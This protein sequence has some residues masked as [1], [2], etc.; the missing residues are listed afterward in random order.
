MR[1]LIFSYD[2][3]PSVG[4]IQSAMNSLAEGIASRSQAE[5][6]RL[7]GLVTQTHADR[8]YDQRFGFTVF[9]RPGLLRLA[10]LIRDCDVLHLAGPALRPLVLAK[11]LQRKVVIQH[12]GYQAICPDGLLL[13]SQTQASCRDSFSHGDWINCLRC[14]ANNVGWI[15]GLLSVGLGY[16]RR[17]LVKRASANV[18]VSDHVKM[19]LGLP[20]SSTIY[21]GTSA[22][23]TPLLS[24]AH[25][26]FSPCFV[27][28]GRLVPEKGV[29]VLLR[30]SA[31]L[32]AGRKFRLRI[33]GDGPELLRLKI[34]ASE[35]RLDQIARFCGFVQGQ[36]LAD[37]IDDSVAVVMP[38][39]CEE[40]APLSAI[41]QMMRG[42]FIIA[43]DIGGLSEMVGATGLKF[44]PGSA[45]ELA[46]S[47]QLALDDADLRRTL[48]F[49]AHL[50]AR[51][52]F[53]ADRMVNDHLK[54]Y[55][56]V[57]AK[58]V[59]PKKYEK[60][61]PPETWLTTVGERL[62]SFITAS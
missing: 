14:R 36:Q 6:H 2:W 24:P 51:Q 23:P 32:A 7:L 16:P 56:E 60:A 43:S 8:E 42:K 1:V 20:S 18:S 47:M 52:L 37:L 45:F 22:A 55:R 28:V 40:A 57:V 48:A 46:R 17:W 5:G 34:L 41:E 54:L 50:R 30:A 15:R 12:H 39:I 29:D 58:S 21:N 10:K 11:L 35:L 44:S 27:F 61:A 9:R 26:C 33:I 59:S 13:D 4:G 25:N 62:K 19:R 31:Q 49:A 38:S 53:S 3:A